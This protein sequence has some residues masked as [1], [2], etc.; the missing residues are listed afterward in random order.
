M[1]IYRLLQV[2][3]SIPRKKRVSALGFFDGV[4]IGHREI[5]RTARTEADRVGASFAVFTFPSENTRIKAD[6]CRLSDTE[7]K[8][9]ELA[10]C[11]ADEVF[12]AEFSDVCDMSA[13]DFVG[14]LLVGRCGAVSCVTGEDYRFGRGAVGDV[15][16][17]GALMREQGG[18]VITVADVTLDG[19]RVST[20]AI[21]E[22][23]RRGETHLAARMLGAPYAIRATVEHGRGVGRTLGYPTLNLPL[24][25]AVGLL[26]RGVYSSR[27]TLGGVSYPAV[28][29]VGV[30]PT[31]G[32]VGEHAECYLIGQC[33]DAYGKAVRVELVTFLRDEIAFSTENE[34]KKQINIDINRALKEFSEK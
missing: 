19:V 28:T 6:A 13:E 18:S 17:L 32:D 34:L 21:K 4:H 31:Y 12:L 22:A 16:L 2:G 11:G 8:L 3:E 29:N 1:Q 7:G 25:G 10:E 5:F 15:T 14:E 30:C 20:G 33:P 27:A 23:L 9:E 24:G 26:R